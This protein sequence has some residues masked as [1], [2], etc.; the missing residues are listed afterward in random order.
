MYKLYN[1]RMAKRKPSDPP[2]FHCYQPRPKDADLPALE[3]TVLRTLKDAR[4]FFITR[5]VSL[6]MLAGLIGNVVSEPRIDAALCRLKESGFVEEV[7]ADKWRAK[8]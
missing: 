5:G 2:N 4:G 6:H 1:V 8:R 7:S 3:A